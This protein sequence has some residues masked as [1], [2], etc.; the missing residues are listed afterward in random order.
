MCFLCKPEKKASRFRSLQL[1]PQNGFVR[2]ACSTLDAGRWLYRI[3]RV[4][5]SACL[6]AQ[7]ASVSGAWSCLK[8][9]EGKL[10]HRTRDMHTVPQSRERERDL[11]YRGFCNTA[12]LGWRVHRFLATPAAPHSSLAYSGLHRD[13]SSLGSLQNNTLVTHC[14][15]SHQCAWGQHCQTQ[16]HGAG[17]SAGGLVSP[18]LNWTLCAVTVDSMKAPGAQGCAQTRA[19][20]TRRLSA[21]R[22]A[23]LHS[24]PLPSTVPCFQHPTLGGLTHHIQCEGALGPT[25]KKSRPVADLRLCNPTQMHMRLREPRNS[26]APPT[27]LRAAAPLRARRGRGRDRAKW[28]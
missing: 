18:I 10:R 24:S 6:G 2:S 9:A 21:Q 14:L 1:S 26:H 27:L 4:K 12:D 23:W 16:T 28:A 11:L 13:V 3:D 22:T 20:H 25:S 17:G 7:Q 15:G 5:S 8:E 19:K